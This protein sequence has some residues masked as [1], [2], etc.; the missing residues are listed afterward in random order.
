MIVDETKLH[1]SSNVY[2][3]KMFPM[4]TQF[5]GRSNHSSCSLFYQALVQ[6]PHLY[7]PWPPPAASTFFPQLYP[8]PSVLHGFTSV[9]AI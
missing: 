4:F 9:S 7:N 8:A 2:E 5:L 6:P 3:L 1:L